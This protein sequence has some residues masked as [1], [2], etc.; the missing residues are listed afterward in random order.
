MI[1]IICRRPMKSF[2]KNLKKY[3]KLYR[4]AL[5]KLS[6]VEIDKENL[7]TKIDE[8]NKTIGALRYENTFFL[9]KS[10]TI[11]LGLSQAHAQLERTSSAKFNEMLSIQKSSY[12]KT[13]IGYTTSK[14][15]TTITF[16]SLSSNVTFI[17]QYDN[18]KIEIDAPKGDAKIEN[19]EHKNDKGKSILGAFPKGKPP[20]RNEVKDNHRLPSHQKS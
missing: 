7:S 13:C 3:E 16:K 18:S 15:S 1:K 11:D 8:G 20:K 10:N 4:L 12:D 6:E 19:N 5:K 9:E 2:T 17:P 14:S